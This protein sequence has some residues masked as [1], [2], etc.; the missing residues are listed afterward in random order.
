M[1]PEPTPWPRLLAAALG[2]GLTPPQF[3]RLSLREWRAL[4]APRAEQLT[5][6]AFENLARRFPDEP[7]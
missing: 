6:A 5:R 2:L 3:W 4:V 1:T 7:R